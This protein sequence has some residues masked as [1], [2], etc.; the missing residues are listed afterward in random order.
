VA[1]YELAL[2]NTTPD[3]TYAVSIMPRIE[4][5]L[6]QVGRRK[7]LLPLYRAMKESG[8]LEEARQLFSAARQNYHTVSTQSLEELLGV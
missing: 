4:T 6:T 2:R 5:F 3:N 8:R 1:W 7:Y